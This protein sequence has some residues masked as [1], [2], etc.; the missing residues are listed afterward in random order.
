MILCKVG[1]QI[2]L[3]HVPVS[4]VHCCSAEEGVMMP[5]LSPRWLSVD[6]VSF[7]RTKMAH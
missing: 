6:A 1:S 5:E 2:S 7:R 4:G 3:F